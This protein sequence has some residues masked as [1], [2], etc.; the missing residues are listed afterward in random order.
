MPAPLDVRRPEAATLLATW[1]RAAG[2]TR[3]ARALA[4][5]EAAVGPAAGDVTVG[6]RDRLLLELRRTLFGSQLSCATTCPA[7]DT[8]LELELS[9]E[10][11]QV[12]RPAPRRRALAMRHAGQT[13]RLH[14]PTAR[15]AAD[16]ARLTTAEQ[17]VGELLQRCLPDQAPAELPQAVLERLERRIVDADPQVEI[18]LQITCPDCADCRL[19]PFDVASYL[20]AE[21]DVWARRTLSTVDELARAYGWS[22]ADVL[23]LSSQRQQFYLAAVHG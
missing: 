17:R 3:P 22:E 14:A 4:L 13:I 20:W 11:M 19:A 8:E 23:A 15:D 21:V 5:L 2:D 12:E 9:V 16:A 10:D 1:E 18:D 7:C 6:D